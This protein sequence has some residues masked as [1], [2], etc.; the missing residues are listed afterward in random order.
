M[1]APFICMTFVDKISRTYVFAAGFFLCMCTLIV[2]AALQRNFL[3]TENR[4]ALAAAVAMTYLY[5]FFYV[6]FL[7]GP[8]F[9][10]IGEIWPSQVR[11][12]GFALGIAAMCLSNLVWTAAA[13]AAFKNIGWKYYIFFIV[14]AAFGGVAALK[15]F[16]NTLGRPLEEIA[17]LFGDSADVIVFQN[18]LE[19]SRF[20]NGFEVKLGEGTERVEDVTNKQ[21]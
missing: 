5:V 4:S 3:G 2:E 15:Y 9:F 6:A 14:Q 10:Y 19:E 13:P 7:D 12:Q 16:P 20:E 21:G 8:M 11:A 1:L 18:D 17:T